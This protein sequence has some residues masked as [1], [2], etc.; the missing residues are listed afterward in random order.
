MR[1]TGF[2]DRWH[3]LTLF[4]ARDLRKDLDLALDT[5]HRSRALAPVTALV[6]EL[7]AETAAD[8][9]HLDTPPVISGC[10]AR[11]RGAAARSLLGREGSARRVA[12]RSH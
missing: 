6:R 5:F 8:I 2:V 11:R 12:R 1:R 4:A 9:A 7:V 10:R 3:E